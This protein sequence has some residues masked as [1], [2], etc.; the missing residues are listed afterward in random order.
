MCSAARLW[1]DMVRIANTVLSR[2]P[3]PG[4]PNP[5]VSVHTF[6]LTSYLDSHLV[7]PSKQWLS[8]PDQLMEGDQIISEVAW[9]GPNTLLVK[10][11]DRASK[12]GNVVLFQN[13]TSRGRVVRKLGKEG[14]QGDDGWI[15]Q[16]RS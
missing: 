12:V 14:E 1:Q 3:K 2:Y 16:A 7:D 11:V 4:T 10:E 5:L 15:D 9:V 8:W 6:S 13:G